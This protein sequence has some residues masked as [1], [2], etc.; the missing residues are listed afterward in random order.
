[1]KTLRY[2]DVLWIVLWMVIV[3]L[4]VWAALSITESE[5]SFG[6]SSQQKVTAGGSAP[7]ISKTFTLGGSPIGYDN[8]QWSFASQ[9]GFSQ[10]NLA[11]M[12]FSN[13][14]T[15]N[16][17]QPIQVVVNLTIP[18]DFDAVNSDFEEAAFDVGTITITGT[19]QNTSAQGQDTIPLKLQVENEVSISKIELK[20]EDGSTS[21]ITSSST[22]EVNA[23]QNIEFIFYI[24]NNFD[25]GT[26]IK[27]SNAE[28][29]MDIEDI[30]D[31]AASLTNID[32]GE[33]KDQEISFSIAD[34]ETGNFDVTIEVEATD[35]L[36]GLHGLKDEFTLDVNPAPQA[37]QDNDNDG[38]PDAQDQCANTPSFCPASSN[39]CP[40]D[41]DNDG[42]CDAIDTVDDSVIAPPPPQEQQN[43]ETPM[44]K[45][46]KNATTQTKT[47]TKKAVEESA[48]FL[49]FLGGFVAGALIASGFY[50][51]LRSP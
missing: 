48:L 17:S 40:P 35:E 47:T 9:N 15:I 22:V 33:A 3:A 8:A 38:I 19:E 25:N 31:D 41:R 12:G 34:D 7:T 36:G 26:D 49:S 28:I 20:K 42:V 24:K 46:T 32:P 51:F 23:D 5:L 30:G 50:F 21:D 10:S 18:G 2:S 1:M 37:P 44:Q 43:T 11:L 4:P 45:T 14:Q 16:G 13:G 29:R 39:G 27:F 6:S